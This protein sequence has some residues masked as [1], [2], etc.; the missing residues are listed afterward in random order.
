MDS[1][2]RGRLRYEKSHVLGKRRVRPPTHPDN[3]NRT[4]RKRASMGTRLSLGSA[5]TSPL[6]QAVGRQPTGQGARSAGAGARVRLS[7]A[8]TLTP[9]LTL[10]LTLILALTLTPTMCRVASLPPHAS[11]PLEVVGLGLA[12]RVRVWG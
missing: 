12:V 8:L 2:I 10:T 7:L 9:T 6:V 4:V 1:V 5:T 11:T 3:P